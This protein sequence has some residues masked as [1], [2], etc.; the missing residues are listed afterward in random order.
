MKDDSET[1]GSGLATRKNGIMDHILKGFE[2][3]IAVKAQL[4]NE[5]FCK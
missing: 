2:E 5:E 4:K 3:S 1:S